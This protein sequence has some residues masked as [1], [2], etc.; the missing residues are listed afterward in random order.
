MK[1]TTD[2]MAEIELI[3]KG[4]K[5]SENLRQQA[6]TKKGVYEAQLKETDEELAKL[7]TTAEKAKKEIEQ[8]DKKI[9]EDLE[10][11]KTMI[12]FDLL[13]KWKIKL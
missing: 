7:G 13:K 1:N 10:K 11:I 9:E 3:E 5:A 6:L 2:I 4:L 12:P 8:I